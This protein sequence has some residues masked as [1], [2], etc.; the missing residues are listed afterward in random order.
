MLPKEG[1]RS[2]SGYDSN[3]S[4]SDPKNDFHDEHV[5]LSFLFAI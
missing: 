4:F 2:S 1:C 3:K 5:N